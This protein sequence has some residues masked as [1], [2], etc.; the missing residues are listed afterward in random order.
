MLKNLWS[1]DSVNDY[2]VL[3][4]ITFDMVKEKIPKRAEDSNKGDFGRLLCV[5]GSKN[6]P[7][8]SYFCVSSAVKCGVGLVTA[9]VTDCVYRSLSCKIS[10]CI[11]EILE[12]SSNGTISGNNIDKILLESQKCSAVL[13]GPGMGWNSNTK[14][15]VNEVIRHSEIPLLIDADGINVIS[16]N[17]DILKEAKSPVVITPHMKEM[18]RLIGVDMNYLKLNKFK[19]AMDFCKNYGVTLVLKDHRTIIADSKNGIYL[20]AT[21]NS[22]M[23]KG[24]MGDVLSGMIA[25]FLAQGLSSVDSAVCATYIHG[26]AG[27]KCSKK[28]SKYSMTPTNLINTLPDVFLSFEKGD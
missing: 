23:A 7:G 13:I 26:L 11:F 1:V 2:E 4:K 20:N 9:A 10:E 27:D 5:C 14:F 3:K 12:E 8:A 28:M 21:G 6:M 18:C 17:I 25:S 24:G 19:C 22:G 15:L 16:E